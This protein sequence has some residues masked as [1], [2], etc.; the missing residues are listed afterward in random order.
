MKQEFFKSNLEAKFIKYLLSYTPLPMIPTISSD[1]LIIKGCTYIY[2]NKI[3]KCTKSGMFAGINSNS[4]FEDHLYVAEWVYTT[5][6]DYVV[7]HYNPETKTFDIYLP[8]EGKEGGKYPGI[9]GLTVTDDVIRYQYR[10]MAEVEY[11]G[12]FIFGNY[13]PNITQKFISNTSYYDTQT[14]RFLGEYLRCLRDIYDIDLMGLYNC[15]DFDV[16]DNFYLTKTNIT[17]GTN[18]KVKV[19]L[20]PIKF[21]KNY[22]ICIDSDF[23]VYVRP[24]F[25]DEYLLKD[26]NGSSLSDLITSSATKYNNLQFLNPVSYS[27]S[28]FMGIETEEQEA[29]S[30]TLQSWEKYLYLAIQLDANNDSSIVVVEGNYT[31]TAQHY[32]SDVS[33]LSHMS[34]TQIANIFR[35]NLSL[36]QSN[37]GKQY[38]YAEKLISYLLK[39][40]ID[41]REEIDDNVAN[42]EKAIKYDP[43]L[44]NFYPGIWDN[45]LRYVLYNKYLNISNV[46]YIDKLDI[47]GFVDRDIENAVQKGMIHYGIQRD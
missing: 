22:T 28:N 36:M 5:D 26:S 14:H 13:I 43:P 6:D 32:I 10:P 8:D 34:S 30:T 16:A 11:V 7:H 33:L 29:L 4:Y 19:L 47:L 35:S 9:G 42:I 38:P 39:Y 40:T 2:K 44:A 12:D 37:D 17:E 31:N 23:P 18:S 27:V 15:F 20:I 21:N 1:D 46:D 24:V 25:Y 41:N 45:D 3:L